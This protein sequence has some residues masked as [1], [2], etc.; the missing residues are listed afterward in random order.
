MVL[1]VVEAIR[2]SPILRREEEDVHG[3]GLMTVPEPSNA[4]FFFATSLFCSC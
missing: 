1:V 3:R 2:P 4:I